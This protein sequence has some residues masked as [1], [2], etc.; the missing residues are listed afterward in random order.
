ML[1]LLSLSLLLGLLGCDSETQVIMGSDASMGSADADAQAD[2]T[3]DATPRVDTSVAD[4]EAGIPD[5]AAEAGD[6]APTGEFGPVYAAVFARGCGG[7]NCHLPGDN[8][9]PYYEGSRRPRLQMPNADAAHAA[10]VSQPVDCE[11]SSASLDEIRVVPNDA[12]ASAI[13]EAIFNDVCGRRHHGVVP[14]WVRDE[15]PTIE[16][17]ISAGASR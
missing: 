14:N 7:T 1:R 11:D 8:E 10:L 13:R 4:S 15:W 16:A 3:V 17:W 5:S 12:S 6:A 9:N 2:A